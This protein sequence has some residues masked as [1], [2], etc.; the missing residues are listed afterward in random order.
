MSALPVS[1]IIVSRHRPKSLAR[2]LRAVS[3]M[4]YPALEVVVVADA[5]GL[6]VAQG[7]HVKTV[8]FDAA[9]ISMARNLGV[10]HAAGEV[11]A[12]IDDDA[13]PEPL[14]IAHLVRPFEH[15]DVM[16]SGGF[17]LSRNGISFE[18]T[19][20]TVDTLLR[21]AAL[22]VPPDATSLHRAVP[23]RAIEIKGTNCAYRRRMLLQMGGFCPD[24]R[25]YLDETEL[26]L[27]LACAGATVV[28]VPEAR[29][30]HVK[31]ASALRR[32]DRAPISLWDVGA[33]SAVCLRRH[34][35]GPAELASAKRRL[36]REQRIKLVGHLQTGRCGPDDVLRLLKSLLQ[37][38]AEGCARA[39]SPDAPLSDSAQPFKS[40]GLIGRQTM[41]LSGRVWQSR[42]LRRKAAILADQGHIVR[43]FVF[44]PTAF[45]HSVRYNQ[46]GYWVQ[47]GGLFGRSDRKDRSFRLYGFAGR[48]QRE[49]ARCPQSFR[50]S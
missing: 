32:A 15:P 21:T 7:Y 2:C 47:K 10:S 24:L 43:L 25:Y 28:I 3:Q 45:F 22:T 33:S 18:W 27:R 5:K 35:A 9:N 4:E 20:G 46:D 26:N 41:I 44:S 6:A 42:S 34:G 40:I 8:A 49:V 19:S 30:H 31:E 50:N 36:V 29:V 14:W 38:F 39:L 48:L 11:V 23:G 16:A 13:V 37:G 17:V 12:F 1:L